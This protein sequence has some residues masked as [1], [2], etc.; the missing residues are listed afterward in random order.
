MRE[1]A[2]V[3]YVATLCSNTQRHV[4]REHSDENAAVLSAVS[5]N[6]LDTCQLQASLTATN[7]CS[8]SGSYHYISAN[9]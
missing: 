1:V 6:A 2:A 5:D 9:F 3:W 4:K 8:L 7:I